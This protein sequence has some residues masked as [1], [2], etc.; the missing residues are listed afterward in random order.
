MILHPLDNTRASQASVGA[1]SDHGVGRGFAGIRTHPGV[2][3][4]VQD[5]SSDQGVGRGLRGVTTHLGI[6]HGTQDLSSDQGVGHSLRGITSEQEASHGFQGITPDQ[7]IG[8][9]MRVVASDL[10]VEGSF[11]EWQKAEVKAS[12]SRQTSLPTGFGNRPEHDALWNSS[13]GQSRA[14]TSV[15][16]SILRSQEEISLLCK[17]SLPCSLSETFFDDPFQTSN[18][19]E[20]HQ[21]RGDTIFSSN[22]SNQSSRLNQSQTSAGHQP[23]LNVRG[24][25]LNSP[26]LSVGHPHSFNMHGDSRLNS[27]KSSSGPLPMFHMA[28]AQV[29]IE[30]EI[31]DCQFF[32][33]RE[34]VSCDNPFAQQ[35]VFNKP[36]CTDNQPMLTYPTP[37]DNVSGFQNISTTWDGTNPDLDEP[38]SA[39]GNS[40]GFH[41]NIKNCADAVKREEIRGQKGDPVTRPVTQPPSLSHRSSYSPDIIKV[42]LDQVGG[43]RIKGMEHQ[44]MT[45]IAKTYGPEEYEATKELLTSYTQSAKEKKGLP[46]KYTSH[47]DGPSV[48]SSAHLNRSS[49]DQEASCSKYPKMSSNHMSQLS[50]TDPQPS[51]PPFHKELELS[52]ILDD[53]DILDGPGDPQWFGQSGSGNQSLVLRKPNTEAPLRTVG[54]LLQSAMDSHD[55]LELCPSTII[56]DQTCA[57]DY[58]LDVIDLRSSDKAS[59]GS[60]S[61]LSGSDKDSTSPDSGHFDDLTMSESVLT[62]RTSFEKHMVDNIKNYRTMKY[63][64]AN[65]KP[66]PIHPLT[67]E[68]KEVVYS[69]L[70]T[71]IP[72]INKSIIGLCQDV[73]GFATLAKKDKELLI[74]R[75]YYDI[76]MLTNSK[77]FHDNESYLQLSDG[78]FYTRGWMERILNPVIA[79]KIVSFAKKFN[80]LELSDLE[81]AVLCAI[82]LTAPGHE[83]LELERPESI[84]QMNSHYVDLLVEEVSKRRPNNCSRILVDIFRLLPDLREIN[85]LQR[86]IIA[87][88]STETCPEKIEYEP[89]APPMADIPESDLASL[90]QS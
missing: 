74:K 43:E 12:V 65:N 87:S 76:W 71:S 39:L 75:G 15:A 18:P 61:Q 68:G 89:E 8:H 51:R 85:L 46:F 70:I 56:D 78:T 36:H 32:S 60:L 9:G 49:H 33:V 7:G 90:N 72:Q 57:G 27:S 54:D 66:L 81:L 52:P 86:E 26:Q 48:F 1:S 37:A 38:R 21:S 77:M 19:G 17:P 79:D 83:A 44:I 69:L 47:D 28:S 63:F 55:S 58:D 25:I 53:M 59:V 62:L 45:T 10:G 16:A 31:E 3:H 80:R 40:Y 13:S 2:G 64:V 22:N 6:S 20:I 5:L 35:P 82:Q 84:Q 50:H 88:L 34:T 41:E 29:K 30:P 11:N 4:G 23:L 67:P 73:P 42:L 14:K 24:P